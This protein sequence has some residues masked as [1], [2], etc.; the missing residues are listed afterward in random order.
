MSAAVRAGGPEGC[1]TWLSTTRT[2]MS[3]AGSRCSSS[4]TAYGATRARTTCL[5]ASS[6]EPALVVR[7]GSSSVSA[8]CVALTTACRSLLASA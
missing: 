2:T 6:S 1:M 3:M 5:A 4:M 8:P 7:R